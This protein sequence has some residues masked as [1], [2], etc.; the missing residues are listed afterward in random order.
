M[1]NKYCFVLDYDGKP[2]SPTKEN[3]GWFLIRKG[4]ATLEKK[5]PMTIRLNKR[6]ED[7]DLDKSKM[8]VGIDDGSKHV[9]LSMVQEGQKINKVVF[10]STLELRQDVK[11]LLV[12]R[13]MWRRHK[14]RHKRYRPTRFNNRSS[15]KSTGRIA[16]S[17]KQKKQS[18]IRVLNEL[19][20][21]IRINHIHLEDVAI[22]TRAMTDGYKPYKWQYSKSN[23]L[24]ENIRKATIMR[25]NNTCQ[26]CK[27]KNIMMEV[28]H[29]VPKRLNGSN[30]IHNLITL[31]KSC[32][33]QVTGIE[34]KYIDTLQSI[35]GKK[36]NTFL[37][38]ASHVMIGKTYLQQELTKIASLRLT[39]GGDTAN[40]RIDWNINKSHSNDAIVITGLIPSKDLD[41]EEYIVKP[42][43]RKSKGKVSN[44][45]GFKYRDFVSFTNTK[46]EKHRGYINALYPSKG[47]YGSVKFTSI[48][49][50]KRITSSVKKTTLL[51]RFTNIYW[52]E[53]VNKV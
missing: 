36:T 43:R 26:M 17:I 4:R 2:L 46:K 39:T 29:I 23:R 12:E 18:I 42:I 35:V 24:D 22:D 25:D 7:K 1:T 31:C 28:H 11:K 34:E 51:W 14:R 41:I 13:K 33:K 27:K 53:G 52:L 45:C 32:H 47:T 19:N 6:V 44:V 9:G 38:H 16:P 20:K 37:N 30:S 10:K 8:H 15:S 48:I 5:Y 50:S 3:K 21:H 40:K 49:N